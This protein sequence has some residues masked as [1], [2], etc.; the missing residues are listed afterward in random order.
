MAILPEGF[1]V[2]PLPYLAALLV[3]VGVV[4]AAAVRRRPAV[5]PRRVLAFVPWMVFG[6]AAHVLYVVDALPPLLRPLGGTAAV[7]LAVGALGVGT[8]VAAD[9]RAGDAVAL[10]LAGLGSLL[11]AVTVADALFVGA[12]RGTLAPLVPAVGLVAA[13]VVAAAAWAV[14]IRAYPAARLTGAVGFLAVF[15]HA[16]D[17]V[18]TAVGVDLLGFGERTPLSRAIIEFAATLP[19]EPYLGTVW[20]F[21]LVKLVIASGIVALFV[22]Y[23]REDPAEGYA[24]LGFVAAVGL[25]P[26]AHNLLLFTVLGGA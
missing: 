18:S 1:S 14:L 2:P 13:A 3:A 10:V 7:Y 22:D 26:G 8:F 17:A 12:V 25:G 16:L 15:G 4:A 5:T 24:L 9:A 21:V 19:T 20:L 6:S 23:V 11:V